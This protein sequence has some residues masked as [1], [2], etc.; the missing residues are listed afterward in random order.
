VGA[1]S[2]WPSLYVARETGCQ[3]V[4]SDIPREGMRIASERAVAEG[5][6]ERCWPVVADGSSL[7]FMS[8]QFDAVY[9][10]DVLC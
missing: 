8:G 1:G 10:C 7:P 3:V 9:H 2:G 5:L 6:H 4:L